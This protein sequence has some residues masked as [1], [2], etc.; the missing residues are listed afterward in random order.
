MTSHELWVVGYRFSV[1]GHFEVRVS[2]LGFPTVYRNCAA[3]YPVRAGTVGPNWQK[4]KVVAR[5]IGSEA[6]QRV[7]DLWEASSIL[8]GV[9]RSFCTELR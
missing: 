2:P 3:S 7:R 9:S 6:R 5:G 1:N 8:G 4:R